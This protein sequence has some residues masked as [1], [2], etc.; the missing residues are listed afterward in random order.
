MQRALVLFAAIAIAGSAFAADALTP[1]DYLQIMEKSKLRYNVLAEPSKTPAEEFTCPRRDAAMRVVA[2]DGERSLVQWTMRPAAEK[3]IEE[4]EALFQAKQ[5]AA[6]A[7]KYKAATEA[8][9]E[10]VVAWFS[11]ADALLF[12][13]N[14]AARALE[15]YD[16]AIALDPTLP[17][18][19]FFQSTAYRRVGRMPEAREAVIQALSRYPGYEGIWQG[20]EA[21]PAALGV[22]PVVRHRFSPPAGYLGTK[23]KNGID[24]FIGTD[25]ERAGYAMC[26]AVWANE[27]RFAK[28]RGGSKGWSLTEER[29]CV[30]NQLWM[31]FNATESRLEEEAKKQGRTLSPEEGTVTSALPPLERHLS[32]VTRQQLLDGYI[33]FE[34]IGQR[35]PL[36][37]SL[38]DDESKAQIEKYVRTFLLSPA[39]GSGGPRPAAPRITASRNRA[40]RGARASSPLPPRSSDTPPTRRAA[41]RGRWQSTARRS[42]T[43]P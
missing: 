19:Y 29:A 32:E 13:A 9:P 26:K 41:C 16:K 11:W 8:D 39:E 33:L 36:A 3:L 1:A 35:C 37:L 22:K 28:E 12:G 23:G 4:G 43:I 2:K 25:G 20:L 34:I 31:A 10:A 6:A 38:I 15:L 40:D 42:P 17:L 18:G 5:Y 21:N 7:E 24:V 27:P 30:I 14:D